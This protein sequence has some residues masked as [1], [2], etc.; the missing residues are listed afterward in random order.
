[1]VDQ[2]QRDDTAAAPFQR[3]PPVDR[4]VAQSALVRA[5]AVGGSMSSIHLDQALAEEFADKADAI[6][7][8]KATDGEF[9]E[10]L[11]RNHD[12]WKQIQ[13]IQKGIAPADDAVLE[14]LEK[15]RLVLLDDIAAR[16]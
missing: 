9:R 4:L 2:D 12:L 11:D 13:Q 10:L 1:L 8:L 3:S 15:R 16:L 14:T 5:K 7:A 6:H